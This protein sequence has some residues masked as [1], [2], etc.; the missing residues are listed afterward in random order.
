MCGQER[1]QQRTEQAH[2]R[3]TGLGIASGS[4]LCLD[5]CTAGMS[6][7]CFTFK[8][9]SSIFVQKQ[10]NMNKI[11]RIKKDRR[12]RNFSLQSAEIVPALQLIFRQKVIFVH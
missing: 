6:D 12:V 5:F 10:D 1:K 3:L 4:I 11:E 8:R 2:R 7:A 9:L